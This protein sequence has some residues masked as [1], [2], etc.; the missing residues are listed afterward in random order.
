MGW[1]SKK[2]KIYVSSV[3]YNLAGD[4]KDRVKYL[5]TTVI[6]KIVSDNNFSMSDAIQSALLNGPGI[7]MRSYAR[8][9]RVQ[10]YAGTIGMQAGRL[11]GPARVDI[12]LLT[13]QLPHEP[14]ETISIDTTEI[15]GAEYA[16]WA[17]QWMSEN[18]PTE[19]DADYE[20]DYLEAENTVFIKF[21]D[22]HSYSF[23]PVGFNINAQ[24]LY[25]GYLLQSKPVPEPLVLGPLVP[26]ASSADFPPTTDWDLESNTST[27][28]QVPLVKTVTVESTFSDGR[29]PETTSTETP[30]EQSF[31]EQKAV[32]SKTVFDGNSTGPVDELVST[33]TIQSNMLN[34]KVVQTSNT[35][36]TTE[37]LPG[38]VI[39]TNK[40]TT[41][42][43]SVESQYAYRIDTQRVV[44]K[45]W[46]ARKT[47]IYQFGTG[48]AVLDGMFGNQSNN[49]AYF[50]FIPVRQESRMLDDN[51]Y[52]GVY[53]QNIKAYKKAFGRD[54]KYSGLIKSLSA[55]KSIRDVDY[56]YVVFGVALNTREAASLKYVY[57]FFQTLMQSGHGGGGYDAWKA[58]WNVANIRM[59]GWVDWKQ[60]QSDPTN[61]LFGKPEPEKG[62]YPQAPSN[63]LAIYSGTFS[64]NMTISWN[65]MAE[66][67]GTGLGRPG[68]KQGDIWWTQGNDDAFNEIVYSGGVVG[69]APASSGAATLT[70][71]DS[72]NTYR[73]ISTRGLY[74]N[75]TIYK[76]KGVGTSIGECLSDGEVSGFVLPLNE[77]AFRAM[78]LVDATQMSQANAYIVLNSYKVVKQK[79]YQTGWF[80]IIL[81]IIVIVI[82]VLSAGAGGASAGLLGTAAAVGASLGFVGMAAIIV[83]AI[84]NALAA[85]ILTQIIMMGATAL[86]GEKIG[87]I[88]GAIASVIAVSAGSSMASGQGMAATYSNMASAESIMRLS[89][90]AGNGLA[91]Y[92]GAET[93]QIVKDTQEL[94]EQYK[95]KTMEILDK[96][97]STLG[98]G[99]ISLDPMALTEIGK[100]EY[101]P[102]SS[103]VFLGRTLLTGSDIAGM[104]NDMLTNF[105]KMT[106]SQELS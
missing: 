10:G 83:G 4:E 19:M 25:A 102:E 62:V 72:S 47:F 27:P 56:G 18:H 26:V 37:T 51:Y 100:Y 8:W 61:P 2:K 55:N 91:E 97:E 44:E 52:G 32:F 50:P 42:T 36:T 29:P 15:G 105:T 85:M 68:A 78:S 9:A 90:A 77:A 65:Y 14:N 21:T 45:K 99:Q 63:S 43:E 16:Y 67:T 64:F 69:I 76:G 84:A 95:D 28:V 74:H 98:L 86:F 71:Q 89:V 87:A 20:L 6:T 13:G 23:Q 31:T 92:V 40:T 48:N 59:Q 58:A 101:I 80:K 22:G 30:S 41:V 12:E 104:T 73:S 38:G 66:V 57:K 53:R 49:G 7:R 96:Y 60:A 70:W 24:Y 5:P 1:F 34:P 35:V 54:A 17:E 88:V 11:I 39:K 93:K 75:Y 94:M 79:W 33:K 46:S 3:T 82:T 106:L 103:N 81:V